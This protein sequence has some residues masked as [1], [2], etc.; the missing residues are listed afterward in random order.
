MSFITSYRNDLVRLREKEASHRKELNQHETD[1]AK[2][3]EDARRQEEWAARASSPSSRSSYLNSAE[4]ARKNAIDAGRKAAAA[5]QDL[6]RNAKD[7]ASKMQ[8]LTSAE[9]S[10]RQRL[11]REEEQR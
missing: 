8:S 4:R 9:R 1:A 6:S 10:E 11:D 3:L 7:Q 2:A 5:T